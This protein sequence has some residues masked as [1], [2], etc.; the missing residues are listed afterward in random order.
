MRDLEGKLIFWLGAFITGIICYFLLLGAVVVTL[1]V[2][3]E[4]V[5]P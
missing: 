4:C 5:G 3:G 1:Q 2:L